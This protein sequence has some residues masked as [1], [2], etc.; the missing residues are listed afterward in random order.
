V[1]VVGSSRVARPR[2]TSCW[3]AIAPMILDRDWI[4]AI[5]D[6][7]GRV[8]GLEPWEKRTL[9][10]T[11]IMWTRA[12]GNTGLLV[13]GCVALSMSLVSAAVVSGVIV[14]SCMADQVWV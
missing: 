8:S 13:V 2:S 10:F 4:M 12:A 5:D 3:Y 14:V 7:V 9:F 11:S 6:E 1:M